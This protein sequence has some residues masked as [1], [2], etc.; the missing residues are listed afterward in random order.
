MNRTQK[1]HEKWIEQ[2]Y[3]GIMLKSIESKYEF[4]RTKNLQKFKAFQDDEFLVTDISEG[5]GKRAGMMGRLHLVTC[6]GKEFC[7]SARGNDAYYR[8]LFNNKEKYI[9]KLATIRYQNLTPDGIPRFPVMVDIDRP[10]I[11]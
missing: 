8:E 9:G 4:T 7:S 11:K 10:D 2:G 3:E 1:E 6:D 5:V